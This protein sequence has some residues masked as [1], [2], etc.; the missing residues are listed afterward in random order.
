MDYLPLVAEQED[1]CRTIDYCTDTCSPTASTV[2]TTTVRFGPAK[3]MAV[4]YA[5]EDVDGDGDM[6]LILH[7]RTQ[8]T[9]VS[10]LQ[11]P[12]PLS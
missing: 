4:Q 5:L 8:E 11:T 3:A 12:Q 6:A 2:N 1:L 7:F 10:R 9:G